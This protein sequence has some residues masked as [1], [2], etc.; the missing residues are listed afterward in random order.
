[1]KTFAA[2]RGGRLLS[3]V[4]LAEV[5]VARGL[6]LAYR[7]YSKSYVAEERAAKL[8]KRGAWAGEFDP[9]WKWR[10]RACRFHFHPTRPQV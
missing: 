2:W 6:A 1:V 8:A 9:P 10:R 7:R 3:G 5:L 4:D